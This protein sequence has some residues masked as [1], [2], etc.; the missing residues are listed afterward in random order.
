MTGDNG[1]ELTRSLNPSRHMTHLGGNF[2]NVDNA[3]HPAP[4]SVV[5]EVGEGVVGWV[6]VESLRVVGYDRVCV[7]VTVAIRVEVGAVVRVVVVVVAEVVGGVVVGVIG[8]VVVVG[9]VRL[10]G[11]YLVSPHPLFLSLSLP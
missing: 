9:V 4:L 7:T 1:G 2:P 3:S 11:C 5:L 6:V 10:G 8:V